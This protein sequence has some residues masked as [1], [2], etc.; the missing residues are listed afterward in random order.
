MKK[1]WL[2]VCLLLFL[3]GCTSDY[4]INFGEKI[5]EKIIFNYD[6]DLN[7]VFGEVDCDAVCAEEE[8]LES[9]IPALKEFKDYYNKQLELKDGKTKISLDY[10]YTYDNFEDSYLINQCFQY[11]DFINDDDYYYVSLG[12]YFDCFGGTEFTLKVK[13]DYQVLNENADTKKDGY[14]IWNI[15]NDN[16][17]NKVE[18]QVSKVLLAPKKKGFKISFKV[19]CW[20]LLFGV[21]GLVIFLKRK[22]EDNNE[23]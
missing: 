12:G 2:L 4:E 11:S 21:L 14:Y 1:I 13:S 8:L 3:T 15:E 7:E 17:E 19:I 16:P 23:F 20:L 6:F 5:D 9:E 18:L 10:S 22:F